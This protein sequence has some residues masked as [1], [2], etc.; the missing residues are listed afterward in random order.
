MEKRKK[1]CDKIT[2][3]GFENFETESFLK[4][5]GEKPEN[6]K[7]LEDYKK[8]KSIWTDKSK[9]RFRKWEL[10]NM[11]DYLQILF[12]DILTEKNKIGGSWAVAGCMNRKDSRKIA[13]TNKKHKSSLIVFL[14][15]LWIR[16]PDSVA[17]LIR[18]KIRIKIEEKT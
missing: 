5:V 18:R 15:I 6:A 4:E 13:I 16:I 14:I 1:I 7:D 3:E 17:K 9:E 11:P 12:D 2:P 8:R 10:E